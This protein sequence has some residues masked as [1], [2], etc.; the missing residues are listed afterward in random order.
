[1][2][3]IDREAFTSATQIAA[4]PCCD[5]AILVTPGAAMA[6]LG[7]VTQTLDCVNTLS[8]RRLYRWRYVSEDGGTVR[9]SC[10][11][12]LGCSN[13]LDAVH[14]SSLIVLSGTTPPQASSIR[15]AHWIRRQHRVGNRFIALGNAVFPLAEA[16]LLSG[17][18]I[19]VHWEWKALFEELFDDVDAADQLYT[20]G[21]RICCSTCS[22]A[23]VEMIITLIK[24]QHGTGLARQVQE[25]LNRPELRPPSTPQGVPLAIKYGTRNQT[26]LGVVTHILTSFDGDIRIQDLSREFSISRRNLE[27]QFARHTGMSPLRFIQECRLRKAYQL[28]Q[29]TDM[30]VLE[31]ALA[32]GFQSAPCFRSAFKQKY[33][34]NPSEFGRQA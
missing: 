12:E 5:V 20:L 6:D 30:K 28:L 13:E 18:K 11:A 1:M 29:V 21:E 8:E 4:P 32:C 34:L 26:F 9:L 17:S 33:G 10:G 3:H 22:D 14:R 15:L 7:A 24:D 27:R 19:A 23:T 16:G 25:K 31:V 2:E